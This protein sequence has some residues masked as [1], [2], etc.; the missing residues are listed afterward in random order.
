MYLD[1]LRQSVAEAVSAGI[2]NSD[3]LFWLGFTHEQDKFYVSESLGRLKKGSKGSGK[4]DYLESYK[5]NDEHF[6]GQKVSRLHKAFDDLLNPGLDLDDDIEVDED[7]LDEAKEE[8]KTLAALVSLSLLAQEI[9]KNPKLLPHARHA[10]FHINV[11]GDIESPL[12]PAKPHFITDDEDVIE[13]ALSALTA[14]AKTKDLFRRIIAASG[15]KK[16]PTIQ[17]LV[18]E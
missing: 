16:T 10:S 1:V 6:V 15:K 14:N 13:A 3:E 12:W 17:E 5:I 8:L 9:E 4:F 18:R 7:E 11:S 2:W